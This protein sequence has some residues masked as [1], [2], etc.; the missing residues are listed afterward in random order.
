M[1]NSVTD[2]APVTALN[3]LI[4]HTNLKPDATK[5]DIVKL[6]EEAV[7]HGF[8][9]VCVSPYYVQLAKKTL[10]KAPVK[11]VTVVG[12]P[13]GYSA[14]SSKVEETK[15]AIMSGADEIDMVMNISA[16]KA[17]D[18]AGVLNDI[19]AVVTACHLQ[20][21]ICKVIIETAYLSDAE[22]EQV[23]RFCIDADADY[24]KTSTGYAATGATVE[25][26]QKMRKILPAK[27]KIK[28][29]GGIRDTDFAKL[30]V[31][32]GASR[33]GTSSGTSIITIE[34]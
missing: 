34:A 24:V 32:A 7:E 20:N 8:A 6:C 29:S 1:T 22:L 33:L 12:F 11:I 15:K 9:A 13:F 19:Q 18:K 10:K 28:A 25:A 4:E 30:L 3:S 5:E 26:V 31:E 21:K 16:L 23:C 2:T 14:T 27:I 17:G